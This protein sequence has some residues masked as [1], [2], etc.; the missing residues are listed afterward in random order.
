MRLLLSASV[1][2]AGLLPAAAAL[3]TGN[4]DIG[5]VRWVC[6]NS[7]EVVTYPSGL[8]TVRDVL[9]GKVT[10]TIIRHNNER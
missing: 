7:C 8:V 2:L 1:V 6:Q 4:L 9:G 3:A 5:N 10:K